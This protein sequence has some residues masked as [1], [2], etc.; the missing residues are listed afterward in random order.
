MS[1][2]TLD[3]DRGAT[4]AATVAAV[5]AAFGRGD[6]AAIQEQVAE[7]VSWDADWADN[8][9]QRDGG[10][11]HFR[12]RRGPAGVAEFFAAL[13]GL[14]L[15]EFT[16]HAIVSSPELAIAKVTVEWS[17]PNGGR[18]RDE[19]L[20]LWSFDQHGRI[21]ALRHYIDTAKHLAADRGVDTTAG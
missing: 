19:E 21:I 20:H 1:T 8:Y 18:L 13:S 15:H 12:P 6:V 14:T 5:Y 4:N 3:A 7:D 17:L 10:L 9:A 16:V 2:T 11:D